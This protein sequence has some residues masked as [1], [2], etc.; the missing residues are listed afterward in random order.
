[1]TV[2]LWSLLAFATRTILLLLGTVGVYR[3]ARILTGRVPIREFRA[4]RVEGDDWYKR[5]MRA[6][7]NC[8]ENLPVF[9]VIVLALGASGTAGPGIDRICMGIVAARVVQSAI[10][11]GMAPTNTAASLRFAFF[12]VQLAGF[13]ALIALIVAQAWPPQ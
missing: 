13:L 9:A 1:M 4:D 11:V 2:P 7:A 5:A 10:H 6:H 8:I 12:F 3:W